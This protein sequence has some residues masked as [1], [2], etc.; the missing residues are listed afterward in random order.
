[1]KSNV[2]ETDKKIRITLG[3]ILALVGLYLRS[4][5]GLAGVVLIITGF[6]EFCGVYKLFGAST[7]GSENDEDAQFQ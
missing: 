7:C 5:G 3:V 2:G 4:W 1:M 6:T